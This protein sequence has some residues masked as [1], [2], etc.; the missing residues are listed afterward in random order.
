M[1]LD[2]HDTPGVRGMSQGRYDGRGIGDGRAGRDGRGGAGQSGCSAGY[3]SI[4]KPIK[5]GICKSIDGRYHQQELWRWLA[6]TRKDHQS[7]PYTGKESNKYH[8]MTQGRFASCGRN[9]DRN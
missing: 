2:V 1:H 8:D 9:A 6:L 4:P 5:Y 7:R 3:T